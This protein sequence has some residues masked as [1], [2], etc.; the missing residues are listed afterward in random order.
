VPLGLN[1]K[2]EL[3]RRVPIFAGCSRAE[4]REVALSADDVDF[5]EGHV[6]TREGRREREF[7]VVVDGTVRVTRD[8]RKVAELGAGDWLGE[9]AILTYSRRTAT[10]TA[11]SPVRALV[12]TDRAFRRI[13]ESTP[14]IALRVLDSI[15]KRLERDATS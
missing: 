1:A 5:A 9:I 11:T 3:L 6:L 4:L 12:V 2:I 7:F 14:R 8:G 15:G 10:A 13:V